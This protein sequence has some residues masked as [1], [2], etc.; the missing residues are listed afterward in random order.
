M[1]GAIYFEVTRYSH[2]AK[3]FSN[4]FGNYSN[5]SKP[6]PISIILSVSFSP[7]SLFM[8]A[9]VLGSI[10]GRKRGPDLDDNPF[11]DAFPSLRLLIHPSSSPQYEVSL[12]A[13]HN[14]SSTPDHLF[15]DGFSFQIVS[16]FCSKKIPTLYYCCDKKVCKE[17]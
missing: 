12:P 15:F 16:I 4:L 7:L 14:L 3:T 11:S 1:H 2:H 9:Q 17:D 13:L 6:G 5:G 10:A 8:H